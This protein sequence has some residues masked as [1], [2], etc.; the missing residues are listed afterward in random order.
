L[1]S[2]ALLTTA[3]ASALLGVAF[4]LVAPSLSPELTPYAAGAASVSLFALAVALTSVTQVF[5]DALIGLYRGHYQLWRNAFFVVAKLALLVAAGTWLAGRLGLTIFATWMIG[6]LLSLGFVLWLAPRGARGLRNYRPQWRWMRGLSRSA[7]SHH[8]L[9]IALQAPGL[10]LP[11]VVAILLSTSVNAAFYMAW[12]VLN[13]ILAAPRALTTVLYAVGSDN[14]RQL[15]EKS[16]LTIKLSL[17]VGAPAAVFLFVAAGTILRVFGV[18]YAEQ[19]QASLRILSLAVVAVTVKSHF[20]ARV[21]VE[22][23]VARIAPVMAAAA[24]AEVG[25]AALGAQLGGLNGLS[26][27]WLAVVYVEA[28]LM[29]PSVYRML[30]GVSSPEAAKTAGPKAERVAAPEAPGAEERTPR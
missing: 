29:W 7:L 13:F 21:R 19:A 18:T 4:A 12:M 16:R 5:D 1:L 9:N 25:V 27:G 26:L 6:N 2:T 14:P 8:F 17:A 28:A 22:R 23:R 30:K 10:A 3:V 11:V 24:L 15:S 20:I